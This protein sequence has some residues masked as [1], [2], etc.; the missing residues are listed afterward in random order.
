MKPTSNH[1]TKSHFAALLAREVAEHYKTI[2]LSM[3]LMFGVIAILDILIVY[4]FRNEHYEPYS[5]D[6][7]AGVTGIIAMILLFVF[8]CIW[9]SMTMHDTASKGGRIRFMMLPAPQGSKFLVRWIVHVP[10]F[11]AAF[12]VCI[13]AAEALRV[14]FAGLINETSQVGFLSW[15]GTS[16][17]ISYSEFW[18]GMAFF[19]FMQS[20]Y[21][22]GSMLWPRNSLLKTFGVTLAMSAVSNIFLG[23]VIMSSI[24]EHMEINSPSEDIFHSFAIIYW[25]LIAFTLLNTGLAYWRMHDTDLV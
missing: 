23:I 12:A 25:I 16:A 20:A 1:S 2:M 5:S 14:I 9:A 17:A 6:P 19:I 10:A 11:L 13:L 3:L 21:L 15:F 8:G 24:S 7:T 4:S 22:L 18:K